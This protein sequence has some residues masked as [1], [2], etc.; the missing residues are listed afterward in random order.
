M[1]GLTASIQ[2]IVTFRNSQGEEARGTLIN[3]SRTTVVIEV[4]N[5]YSIV[6]LSEVL[7]ELIIYRGDTHIYKGR[8]VVSTLVNTGLMVVAS[9]TLVDGWFDLSALMDKPQ[10]VREEVEDFIRD[11]DASH[12]LRPGMQLVVT[13]MR[14]FLGELNHWLEQVDIAAGEDSKNNLGLSEEFMRELE[15]PILLRFATQMNNFEKEACQISETEAANHKAFVHR[16]LHPFL[17]RAPFIHRTFQKPLG[18]AGD[19]EMVNMIL[20]DPHEGA[21][22]YSKIINKVFLLRGPAE[23]HRNRIDLLLEALVKALE[24]ADKEDRLLRVLNIGCGPA[25]E[26][27][28]LIR[29][30]PLA[31]RCTLR[32]LDFSEETLAYAKSKIDDAI[33]DSGKRPEIDFVHQSVNSLLKQATRRKDIPASEAF[34]FVYC[35]GLFDYLSD[36]VCSR[37]LQLFYQWTKPGKLILTTNVHPNNPGRFMMEYAME[38]HLIHRNEKEMLALSPELGVQ[39][40]YADITGINVFLEICKAETEDG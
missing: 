9:L 36:K 16:D 15:E 37:L 1:T 31:D 14:S 38:W 22:T 19:Y 30:H 24:R 13:E 35:A 40:T 26:I 39:R 6:Q 34:D 33:Q 10:N 21:S 4:Y 18:F 27:Q 25:I 5:P 23:A 28:R 11:W 8:A 20:R 2:K 17:M 7:Q 3:M 32:L 29:T 12:T